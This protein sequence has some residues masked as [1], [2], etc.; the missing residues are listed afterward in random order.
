MNNKKKGDDYSSQSFNLEEIIDY[1][2][3][4]IV[5]NDFSNEEYEIYL[6]IKQFGK[7]GV[8]MNYCTY[9]KVLKE[10]KNEYLGI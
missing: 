6:D 2:F 3:M 7:R 1:L 4:K 9:K 5:D 10:M 8:K